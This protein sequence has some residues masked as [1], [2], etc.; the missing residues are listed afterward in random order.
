MRPTSGK[1]EWHLTYR[2]NLKCRHCNRLSF[3]ERPHTEDMTLDDARAFV[4][5]A[6]ARAWKPTIVILG[7]EPTL[8]PEFIQFLRI[9]TTFNPGHVQIWSNQWS[10]AARGAIHAARHLGPVHVNGD[11]AKKRGSVVHDVHDMFV[12][13]CDFGRTRGP[14]FQHCAQ[15]GGASLDH[16]G[17][18]PCCCGG[19]VDAMMG[20]GVR[21]KRLDDLFDPEWL[22][23]AT[24]ALCARC[25]YQGVRQNL[26]D[27]ADVAECEERHGS[28]VSPLWAAAIDDR[29]RA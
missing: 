26:L 19:A 16:E 2:C 14:C 28:K 3:L 4:E 22:E 24:R 20:L 10:P 15:I 29:E 17:L 1:V 9:A 5:Q 12:A 8:H 25:G 21:T 18:S 23:R 6:E 7:G 27:P 11:T 13:P